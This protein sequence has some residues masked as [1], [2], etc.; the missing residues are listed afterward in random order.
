VAA[1]LA[2]DETIPDDS[3]LLR[4]IPAQPKTFIVWNNNEKRWAVSS[5]AFKNS[6]QNPIAMSVNLQCVLDEHG[7]PPDSVIQ[8][9]DRYGLAAVPA[10]LVR[11][12]NQAVKREPEPGDPSHAHVPGEKPGAVQRALAAAATWVIPPKNLPPDGG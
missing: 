8:D 10:S 1:N 6:K 9:P 2:D 3:L 11:A 7:L 12:H 5:Q 4:R